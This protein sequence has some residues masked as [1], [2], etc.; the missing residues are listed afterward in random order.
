[1][2]FAIQR[3]YYR[4]ARN[5]SDNEVLIDLAAG[6]GLE[7]ARFADDLNASATCEELARQIDT[8]RRLGAEGFPC[9]IA[10]RGDDHRQPIRLDYNNPETILRQIG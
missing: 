6:M 10:V 7:V 4:D 9:L 8:G 3:A 2:I 5:P 1:M